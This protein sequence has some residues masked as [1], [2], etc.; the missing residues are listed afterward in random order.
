MSHCLAAAGWKQVCVLPFAPNELG[1]RL[2]APSARHS[3]CR[4]SGDKS[5]S[6]STQVLG[7]WLWEAAACHAD[8]GLC[9]PYVIR[10]SHTQSVEACK[11][12]MRVD[13]TGGIYANATP[14]IAPLLH[15]NSEMPYEILQYPFRA[16][17]S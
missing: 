12:C 6:R 7:I 14:S 10:V 9:S 3:S 1:V 15:D 13:K 4:V 17:L 16:G 8:I 5:Q 11:H 2:W